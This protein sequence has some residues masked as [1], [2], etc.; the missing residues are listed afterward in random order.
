[1]YVKVHIEFLAQIILIINYVLFCFHRTYYET[2]YEIQRHFQH[3]SLNEDI[4][5]NVF[6][7]Y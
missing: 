3:L 1:M 6:L 5:A 7:F 4:C 2:Y